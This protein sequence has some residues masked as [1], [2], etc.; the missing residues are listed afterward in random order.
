MQNWTLPTL[1]DIF[2]Y[3]PVEED[4]RAIQERQAAN[5]HQLNQSLDHWRKAELKA[6]KEWCGAIAALEQLLLCAVDH[7]RADPLQQGLI[8]SGPTPVLSRLSLVSQFQAGVFKPEVSKGASYRFRLPAAQETEKAV[9]PI[10]ELSLVPNDPLATEQFCL[11]FTPQFGLVL[12]LGRDAAGLPAFQFSFDPAQV[13]QAWAILRLRLFVTERHQLQ[14]LEALTEQFAPPVPDYR[15]VMEF[16]RQML[17][18]LASVPVPEGKCPPHPKPD[19]VIKLSLERPKRQYSN[20]H[21]EVELLQA[22]THEV[23][24][25]LTTI[26]TLARSLLKRNKLSA[27][28]VKRLETIDQECTEQI[29]RMELIFRAAELATNPPKQQQ[30][31]LA[32]I[33]L[34][35]LFEQS[36][37]RWKKQAQRRGVLLNFILPKRLPTVFSDSGMLERVLTGLMEKFTRSLPNGGQLNVQIETAGNQLKLQFL[38]AGVPTNS[39]KSLGQ[40]LMFQPE[41]GSLSLNLDV[42]KSL[43]HAMGGKLTVRQRPHQGEVLTIFLPLS[44]ADADPKASVL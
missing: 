2:N 24:T 21:S 42:T 9:A 19:N 44:H 38:S 33:S 8:L 20:Q 32:P 28:A 41:T 3:H 30:M 10:T 17:D 39:L 29:N 23:R 1:S 40:L 11:A 7:D 14:R 13:Q 12:V 22:L 6:K 27:N 16:S 34:E 43:F 36:I 37:P 5:S 26:R 31:R 18:H 4:D 35:N 25:P 15:T